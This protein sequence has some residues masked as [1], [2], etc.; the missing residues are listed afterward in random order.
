MEELYRRVSD[1][2]T[3]GSVV[4]ELRTSLCEVE[5]PIDQF[6]RNPTE[7]AAARHVPAQL[8]PMRG[9]LSVLGLAQA[10]QAVLRMRDEVDG[11]S[12]PRSSPS[13][14]AAGVF[15]RLADNLGALGFLIDMLSVQPDWPSRS[16]PTT[17]QR[18]VGAVMGRAGAA[19]SQP[20]PVE[21]RLIEQAQLLAFSSVR[22]DVPLQEVTRDLERLSHEAQAA[23]QPA[24]A[25]AVLKAQ[26]A[27]DKAADDPITI[28]T[29][30]GELSEALVDFVATATEAGRAGDGQRTGAAAADGSRSP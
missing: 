1:R 17:R 30:R 18:R 29:A 22:D 13:A 4:Q 8:S 11:W 5:K 28:A 27:I 3:M 2:Q 20:A 10:S 6:F 7:R 25:A 24:L 15:D 16:F 14:A 23:D 26:E 12:R 19:P 9:V 21:L